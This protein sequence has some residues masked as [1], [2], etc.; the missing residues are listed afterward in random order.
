MAFSAAAPSMSS[1]VRSS[2]T[3]SNNAISFNGT[4]LNVDYATCVSQHDVVYLSPPRNNGNAMP[5]GDGDIGAMIWCPGFLQ[6]QIQKSD[7]WSDPPPTTSPDNPGPAANWRQVSAGAVAI[8]SEPEMLA[9][10]TKFEQRLSLY[11]GVVS[12]QADGPVGSCQVTTFAS[13]TAGVVVIHYRDQALRSTERYIELSQWRDGHVFALGETAGVLQSLRD[14]R[15]TMIA[16]VEGKT[17]AAKL[18]DGRTARLVIEPSRSSAFTVYIA[19][20]ISPR[21]GDPVAIAKSRIDAA[22]A[23][24]YEE[25]L[26]EHKQHW[27]LFWQK[28]FV[29]LRGPQNDPTA[30]YLENLWHLSLYQ[31]ASC[32]RGYDAPVHNGGIWLNAQDSRS[33][34]ALYDGAK[35]RAMM[36]SLLPS[37]HLELTVPYVETYHRLLPEL[38]A[39]TGRQ[40]EVGGTRFPSL[41]NRWGTGFEEE[42]ADSTGD[43]LNAALFIWQ[44]WRYA[45]DPYFL[46]EKAY[47]LLRSCATFVLEYADAHPES[48]ATA[49]QRGK[50]ALAL[51]ALL[52]AGRE[53]ELDED[54]WGVWEAGL[55]KTGEPTG[56]N[57]DALMTPIRDLTS[58]DV[59]ARMRA[60]IASHGQMGQGFFTPDPNTPNLAY[61]GQICAAVNSLLLREERLP[62]GWGADAPPEVLEGFGGMPPGVLRIFPCFP[63]D[64]AGSFVLLAPGGFRVVSEANGDGPRYVGI[65]SLLG[66]SFRIFNPWGKGVTVRITSGQARVQIS[67]AE[68]L[69]ATSEPGESHVIERTDALLSRAIRIRIA[70]RRNDGPK[71]LNA[72]VLGAPS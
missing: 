20:A 64:W 37:N 8:H 26:R 31:L 27:A 16:R 22:M 70:G 21:D 28:S 33:G 35:L 67:D 9:A 59:A 72:N 29:R 6:M 12:L 1:S 62:E 14:R 3:A 11:T 36:A 39:K 23:R 50:L 38:A 17:A 56:P 41:F 32:L 30:E 52:W 65:K 47:P 46:R 25:L 18:Q 40:H 54:L 13:A 10:P 48:C 71:V 42:K 55:R 69:Y 58:K 51:R 43:G 2:G 68:I 15:Y 7:L 5:I 44:A 63:P 49:L 34:P 45:P 66:G 19:T 61:T 24:G 4:S 53:M 57:P 60:W